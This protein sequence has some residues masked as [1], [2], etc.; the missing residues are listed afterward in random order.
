M[1]MLTCVIQQNVLHLEWVDLPWELPNYVGEFAQ[2]LRA[3]KAWIATSWAAD[4]ATVVSNVI[5][6]LDNT[7]SGESDAPGSEDVPQCQEQV[8]RSD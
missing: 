8:F 1:V 2:A 3:T 7:N 5:A 4:S 6:P